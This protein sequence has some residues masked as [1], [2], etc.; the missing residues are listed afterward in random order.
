[1]PTGVATNDG[2]PGGLRVTL[3][4]KWPLCDRATEDTTTH[5]N[6]RRSTIAY[7]MMQHLQ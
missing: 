4:M 6:L 5:R 7:G 3:E 2:D 1:M